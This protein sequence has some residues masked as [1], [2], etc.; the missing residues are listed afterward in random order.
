MYGPCPASLAGLHTVTCPHSTVLRADAIDLA[1][2]YDLRTQRMALVQ[3]V[4]QFRF[5]FVALQDFVGREVKGKPAG[6][7]NGSLADS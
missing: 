7:Q 3:G 6:R 5:I 1:V 2:I 4:E